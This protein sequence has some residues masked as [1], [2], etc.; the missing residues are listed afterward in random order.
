[1]LLLPICIENEEIK[2]KEGEDILF[3]DQG[4]SLN[5][6]E[7][8]CIKG[9]PIDSQNFTP[10]I[11][12]IPHIASQSGNNSISMVNISNMLHSILVTSCLFNCQS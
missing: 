3:I 4:Y 5:Q 10:V 9:I 7:E 8:I 11:S 2:D 12:L 6:R 1:M